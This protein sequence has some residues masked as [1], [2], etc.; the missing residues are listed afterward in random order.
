M[1][2]TCMCVQIVKIA[3]KNNANNCQVI[4]DDSHPVQV[5]KPVGLRRSY[6]SVKASRGG[7][8]FTSALKHT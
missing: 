6:S 4:Y 5:S 3:D 2:I 7:N 8:F 1:P